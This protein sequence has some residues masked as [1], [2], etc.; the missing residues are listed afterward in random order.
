MADLVRNTPVARQSAEPNDRPGESASDQ[1]LVWPP[2]DSELDAYVLPLSEPDHEPQPDQEPQTDPDQL[3]E[4]EE[5]SPVALHETAASEGRP[6]RGGLAL[7]DPMPAAVTSSEPEVTPLEPVV[8]AATPVS[9]PLVVSDVLSSGALHWHEAVAIVRQLGEQLTHGFS[10]EPQGSIPDVEGVELE[11]TGRLRARL[12]PAGTVPMVRGLGYLLHILLADTAAP[13]RLRLIVSQAVAEVPA[14][15]SVERLMWELAGFERPRR[16]DTLK[17]LYERA[18][19]VKR[20]KLLLTAVDPDIDAVSQPASSSKVAQVTEDV[21]KRA[22]QVPQLSW[23]ALMLALVAG[24]VCGALMFAAVVARSAGRKAAPTPQ[25]VAESTTRDFKSEAPGSSQPLTDAA[26]ADPVQPVP[27][28]D[29][30]PIRPRDRPEND[31]APA[32]SP[33]GGAVRPAM[34]FT[35]SAHDIVAPPTGEPVRPGPAVTPRSSPREVSQ[36]VQRE[37]RRARALFDDKDYAKA[38]DGFQQVAKLLDDGELTGPS[39][40]LRSMASDYAVL[41]RATLSALT[42]GPVYSSGDE[43]VTEPV[44][45]RQYL[46]A[47]A[48]KTPPS[49][50]GVLLLVVNAQGAVESV[51]LE[52][53]NNHYHDRF[54]VS[55]AKT[56]RFKPALKDGQPVKF[57]KRI[58]ITDRAPSDP[59]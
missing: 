13:V 38:A 44:A 36:R 4:P 12:D 33:Q 19:D 56:W 31:D 15:P 58:V 39:A 57:L 2:P 53:P 51:R 55:A 26:P 52:S 8:A 29:I 5:S 14:F 1:E 40:E 34:K 21:A 50:L 25:A 32:R 24:A 43:G 59:Q 22:I 37:Y 27:H 30:S 35:L 42:E 3:T 46:P 54:W 9:I 23:P 11:P 18:V 10:L 7:V 41:S 49:R 6:H 28:H 45:V 16:L 47:P 48:P 20:A 17:Q